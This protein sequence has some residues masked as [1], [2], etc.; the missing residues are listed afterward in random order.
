[1]DY[2]IVFDEAEQSY[3]VV[4]DYQFS[5]I[6]DW[7]SEHL[8]EREAIQKVLQKIN[9]A[10]AQTES[11]SVQYGSYHVTINTDGIQ[12]NRQIDLSE[13]GDEIHA[14]FDSQSDFYQAST[15]GIRAECG[16]EDLTTML[17]NWHNI[18]Y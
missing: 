18:L 10:T 16:L 9:L 2:E 7:V 8:K 4:T 12:V 17:E 5:A 15:E 1:M 3:R 11:N 6:A 14:I 13:A